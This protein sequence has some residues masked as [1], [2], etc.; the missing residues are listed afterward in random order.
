MNVGGFWL[1]S[2]RCPISYLVVTFRRGTRDG[3]S[4]LASGERVPRLNRAPFASTTPVQRRPGRPGLAPSI[5]GGCYPEGG[6]YVARAREPRVRE[7]RAALDLAPTNQDMIELDCVFRAS[8]RQVPL[9]MKCPS[10]EN[11]RTRVNDPC[12][13]S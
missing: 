13:R 3:L 10:H 12:R 11:P 9:E 6:R 2:S 8:R 7:N 5:A 4:A 1:L